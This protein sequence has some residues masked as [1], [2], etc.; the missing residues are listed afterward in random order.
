M[1]SLNN[2]QMV[3]INDPGKAPTADLQCSQWFVQQFALV[4]K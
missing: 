3:R 4:K 2:F 1:L